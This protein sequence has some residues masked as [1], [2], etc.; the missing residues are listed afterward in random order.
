M[1]SCID[2]HIAFCVNWE[3]RKKQEYIYNNAW[4]HASTVAMNFVSLSLS[5]SLSCITLCVRVFLCTQTQTHMY[6]RARA[7][8]RDTT[9]SSV[10]AHPV[11]DVAA[12]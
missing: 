12:P 9:S 1:D 11:A 3:L 4:T 6:T 8:V 7:F 10:W 5:L 2:C